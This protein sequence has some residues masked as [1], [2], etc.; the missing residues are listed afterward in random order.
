MVGIAPPFTVS[1]NPV[2]GRG[3]AVSNTTAPSGTKPA[4]P[5][6]EYTASSANAKV[7]IFTGQMSGSI[8]IRA[9]AESVDAMAGVTLNA[10]INNPVNA[11]PVNA[12]IEQPLRR[13]R[14]QTN[15]GR[16]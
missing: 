6:A 14:S 3:V 2:G 8:T 12:N 13:A 4:K 5:G 10:T 9:I 7:A 15:R 11:N 1:V 16:A